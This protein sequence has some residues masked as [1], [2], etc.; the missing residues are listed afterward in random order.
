MRKVDSFVHTS[1]SLLFLKS[2]QY[3]LQAGKVLFTIFGSKIII[4]AK[5]ILKKL[6][7]SKLNK[8]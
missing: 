4:A 8:C 2:E 6:R 7:Q 3:M 5:N 1:N